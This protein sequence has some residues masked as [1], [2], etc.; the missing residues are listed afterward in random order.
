MDI[1]AGFVL[2]ALLV[3]AACTGPV[4]AAPQSE[5]LVFASR[6]A[7]SDVTTDGV[8]WVDGDFS[9]WELDA[10]GRARG[11]GYLTTAICELKLPV[12]EIVVSWNSRTPP[13]ATLRVEMRAQVAEDLWTPWFSLAVWPGG[14]GA[15]GLRR[16]A[17][18]WVNEDTLVLRE[19]TRRVQLRLTLTASETG[20]SPRVGLLALVGSTPLAPPAKASPQADTHPAWGKMLDVPF[21]SQRWEDPSISGRIC[22]P[23]SLA[24]ILDYYGKHLPTA[25]VAALAY[26]E[27]NGIY[28]NWP[29]LAAAAAELGLASYVTRFSDWEGVEA[30][31]LA[32]HPVIISV[33]FGPG[34]LPGAP[35]SSTSGHLLVVRGFTETGDVYINDPAAWNEESGRTVYDREA[36]LAAWKNGVAIPVM[37]LADVAAR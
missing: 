30:E 20:N 9:G 16:D 15:P 14:R 29:F 32:G 3:M 5:T 24:M 2:A 12:T 22:G 23:T 19:P 36:L 34:E 25:T 7:F 10:R 13:G 28:G 4:Q 1:L 35:I 17:S 27:L 21:R 11:E 6:E 31:I 26:D 18:G 8:C 37:P 33:R